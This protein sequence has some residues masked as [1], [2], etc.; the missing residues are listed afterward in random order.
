MKLE[1]IKDKYSSTRQ[2]EEKGFLWVYYVV[3]RIS[4]YPTWLF[5]KAGLS[6]NQASYISILVG[7]IGCGLLAFGN[8]NIRIAG[9]L[10]CNIWIILDCVDGNIARYK[11]SPSSYGEFLDALSGYLL[12]AFL[13]L[14]AGIAAS[15]HLEPSFKYINQVSSLNLNESVLIIL[16][17]WGSLSILLAMLIFHKF[18]SVFPQCQKADIASAPRDGNFFFYIVNF[19]VQNIVTFSGFLTPMLLLATIFKLLSIFVFLYALMNT[20]VL[21]VTIGRIML[22]SRNLQ[23]SE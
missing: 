15:N 10:L 12:S 19:T 16:G 2:K 4:F 5:L 6:A 13:F 17:A 3:R 11:Q 20:G 7:A 14:S 1:D 22:N 9:A 18:M 8:Y 23:G 21:I